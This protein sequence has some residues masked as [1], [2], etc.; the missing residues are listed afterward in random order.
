[1]P[2]SQNVAPLV[3]PT[4]THRAHPPIGRPSARDHEPQ[5]N[6][7][8][9]NVNPA[10]TMVAMALTLAQVNHFE[11]R[12][13]DWNERY[14]SRATKPILRTSIRTHPSAPVPPSIP[15][16]PLPPLP[17]APIVRV[18]TSLAFLHV[19]SLISPAPP[20]SPGTIRPPPS[21][22][23]PPREYPAPPPPPWAPCIVI[24]NS[25]PDGIASRYL[26]G[27]RYVKEAVLPEMSSSSGS[28]GMS[29]QIGLLTV[30]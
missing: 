26:P 3:D 14:L 24:R 29:E 25:N 17:P 6:N 15:S 19:I 8:M 23:R 12:F 22:L 13:Q 5:K 10:V 30:L 28:W 4:E 20:G 21:P 18:R 7:S 16:T 1:M 2:H 9:M 11:K 27:D